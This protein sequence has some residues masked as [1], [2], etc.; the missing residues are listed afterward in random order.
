M[1]QVCHTGYGE[2]WAFLW[3]PL[4][5][6]SPHDWLSFA[7][8]RQD[9]QPKQQEHAEHA[10]VRCGNKEL[11]ASPVPPRS[12]RAAGLPGCR[13]H[14]CH[15]VEEKKPV[16]VQRTAGFPSKRGQMQAVSSAF[17]PASRI[18]TLH[19][20]RGGGRKTVESAQLYSS[21]AL[22]SFFDGECAIISTVQHQHGQTAQTALKLKR[23]L[24]C[25]YFFCAITNSSNK[26]PFCE[27][28]LLSTGF[29]PTGSLHK[30]GSDK[31]QMR[32]WVE[33]M[34]KYCNSSSSNIYGTSGTSH[35]VKQKSNR[36]TLQW[37]FN[38][39][40]PHY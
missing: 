38:E 25:T 1:R 40:K 13:Q 20:G 36:R 21:F 16:A 22:R 28:P 35:K 2:S 18:F 32:A 33:L 8:A 11:E 15:F 34:P 7:G 5:L 12:H 27:T 10:G 14:G 26:Q 24:D 30:P 37:S 19:G 6:F 9:L 39:P 31:P 23:T 17:T 4:L 29:V 3:Q